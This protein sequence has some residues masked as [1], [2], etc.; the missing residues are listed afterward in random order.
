MYISG[1]CIAS[2]YNSEVKVCPEYELSESHGKGPVDWVIKIGDTIIIVTE[3][4]KED[5]TQGVSQ[6]A[7]Q[8]QASSQCNKKKCTYNKA[9]HEDVIYSIVSTGVD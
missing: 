7:I 5:I 1:S 8:L 4:K 6:N 9:L 3:A 2:C